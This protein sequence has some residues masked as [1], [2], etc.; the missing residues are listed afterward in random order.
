MSKPYTRV[1]SSDHTGTVEVDQVPIVND[2][3]SQLDQSGVSTMMSIKECDIQKQI[4][5]FMEQYKLKA[6]PLSRQQR[7][8]IVIQLL[9]DGII[10]NADMHDTMY[11][12]MPIKWVNK[13]DL[14]KEYPDYKQNLCKDDSSI[15]KS[16]DGNENHSQLSK[17]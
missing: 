15:T 3:G 13:K 4:K 9:K 7:C 14:V 16:N 2:N 11:G 5:E 8:E 6:P 1:I 17:E 12:T 10:S